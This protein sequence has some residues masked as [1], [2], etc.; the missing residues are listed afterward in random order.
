MQR[1]KLTLSTM[2][3]AS[4]LVIDKSPANFQHFQGTRKKEY[5]ARAKQRRKSMVKSTNFQLT[6]LKGYMKEFIWN[7]KQGIDYDRNLTSDL[8]DGL[9]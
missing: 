3:F 5:V 1:D 9:K 4:S 8:I 2:V 7:Q 6:Y